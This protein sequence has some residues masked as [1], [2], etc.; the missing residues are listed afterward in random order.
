MK[1]ICGGIAFLFFSAANECCLSRVSPLSSPSSSSLLLCP[2]LSF[3]NCSSKRS[4][5]LSSV[6]ICSCLIPSLH[7][8][9][10]S[11]IAAW[12]KPP[13][14]ELHSTFYSWLYVCVCLCVCECAY[15]AS[16]SWQ[17]LWIL[18]PVCLSEISSADSWVNFDCDILSVS[19][20]GSRCSSKLVWTNVEV[21]F[22]TEMVKEKTEAK[23]Y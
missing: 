13:F 4:P 3:H 8:G 21:Y 2:L 9:L 22:L 15:C 6:S 5:S 23:L 1:V 19:P 20:L 11:L 18:A 14:E 7:R 16:V 12:Q 17:T 10:R